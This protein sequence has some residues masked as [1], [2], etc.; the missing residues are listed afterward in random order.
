MVGH[1]QHL[2]VSHCKMTS[3]K[4]LPVSPVMSVYV[5]FPHCF[6]GTIFVLHKSAST[7]RPWGLLGAG[8]PEFT[9]KY[10]VVP[11]TME[12]CATPSQ[13]FTQEALLGRIKLESNLLV[14][15]MTCLAYVNRY[16]FFSF[17][18]LFTWKMVPQG[19]R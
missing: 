4:T 1:W 3:V 16:I 2:E 13:H 8:S 18:H 7:H 17:H 6:P 12:R 19:K 14:R 9:L 15:I 10:T 5:G 11:V